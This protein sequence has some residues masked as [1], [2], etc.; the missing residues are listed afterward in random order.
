M[1]FF[2][3]LGEFIEEFEER[4]EYRERREEY[5]EERAEFGGLFFPD[6]EWE[7]E[8][9]YYDPYHH[10]DLYYDPAL[11]HHGV[12]YRGVWHPLEYRNGDWVFAHPHRYG[13]PRNY[14]PRDLSAPRQAG[15]GGY[16]QAPGGQLAAPVSAPVVQHAAPSP[17]LY[18]TACGAT[19]ATNTR[20]CNYC[21]R[22]QVVA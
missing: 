11:G 21:G 5:F 16:G 18:C 7:M 4:E 19:I 8:G 17:A 2:G 15:Y 9:S 6:D 10:G 12:I 22:A 3:G 13:V 20:P 1:G 14:R